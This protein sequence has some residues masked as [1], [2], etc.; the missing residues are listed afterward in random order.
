MKEVE[1]RFEVDCPWEL[2][3]LAYDRKSWSIPNPEFKEIL[4]CDFDQWDV[5][6]GNK[7]TTFR[8]RV[9]LRVPAPG[10]IMSMLSNDKDMWSEFLCTID[11]GNRVMSVKGRNVTLTDFME[12][13][14]HMRLAEDPVDHNRCVLTFHTTYTI[15]ASSTFLKNRAESL[16]SK[17]YLRALKR[18]RAVDRKFIDKYRKTRGLDNLPL[19]R[20]ELHGLELYEAREAEAKRQAKQMRRDPG[21][22]GSLHRHSKKQLPHLHVLTVDDLCSPAAP[23][24]TTV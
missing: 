5:D 13:E 12:S 17:L 24:V 3:V 18:G 16:V 2:A 4:R 1:Q 23:H 10:W 22:V 6:P 19:T 11:R 20:S 8:R 21:S 9:Q 7:V 14:E 15:N